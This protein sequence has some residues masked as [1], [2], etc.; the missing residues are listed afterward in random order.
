MVKSILQASKLVEKYVL[1]IPGSFLV[2]SI[3]LPGLTKGVHIHLS[4]ENP[5]CELSNYY[6]GYLRHAAV[7]WLSL[8]QNWHR[9]LRFERRKWPK[10]Y[11]KHVAYN[12]SEWKGSPVSPSSYQD[13]PC[14]TEETG[15]MGRGL[16]CLKWEEV[17][18]C[19]VGFPRIG[20][21]LVRVMVLS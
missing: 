16:N 6:W 1:K 10:P 2:V 17:Y 14:V 18:C 7:A 11:R 5:F 19:W 15:T 3:M 21:L 9:S 20:S 12:S 8:P 13:V 4:G